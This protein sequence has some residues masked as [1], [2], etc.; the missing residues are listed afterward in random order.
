LTKDIEANDKDII[1]L[2]SDDF[3][4]CENWD[5]YLQEKFKEFN[6]CLFVNDGYQDPNARHGWLSITIPIMTYDCLKQLNKAIY[7]PS[8]IHFFGDT[9]LYNNVRDLCLLKDERDVD[10]VVFEHKHHVTGKRRCDD[11]DLQLT[12]AWEYDKPNY[13]NRAKMFVSDRIKI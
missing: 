4:P 9:E 1:I 12:K 10:T 2:A 6:G 11:V 7:H 13:G 5:L 8:Y 3:F